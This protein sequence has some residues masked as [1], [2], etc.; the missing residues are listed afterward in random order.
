MNFPPSVNMDE[1]R[2]YCDSLFLKYENEK[3]NRMCMAEAEGFAESA[4]KL[5]EMSPV[6]QT[7]NS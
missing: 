3:Y 2:N 5:L 7:V 1:L 4:T 6:S